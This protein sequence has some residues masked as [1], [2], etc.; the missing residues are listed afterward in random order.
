MAYASDESGAWEVYVQ[1]FRQT[2]GKWQVSSGGG[3]QP[4]WRGDGKELFY[5]STD[6]R[7]F[8][9]SVGGNDTFEAGSPRPLFETT[10]PP[11]LAPFRT[12]YALSPDGQRFLLNR[13]HPNPEPSVITIVVNWAG[14]VAR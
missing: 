12:G 11:M 13:L 10:L 8:A 5:V 3:S 2:R 14:D 1:G 6:D 9:S 7:L 4:M